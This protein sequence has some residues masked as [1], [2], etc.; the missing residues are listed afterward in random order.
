MTASS[1]SK[2]SL[3]VALDE[4][5]RNHIDDQRLFYFPSYEI[6]TAFVKDAMQDDLRHPKPEVVELIMQTFKRRFLL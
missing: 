4:L 2:A 3:R 5:M 1:V 6:V